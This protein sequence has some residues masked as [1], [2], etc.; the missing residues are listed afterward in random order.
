MDRHSIQRA[1][2]ASQENT[3][4]VAAQW[5]CGSPQAHTSLSL[6]SKSSSN[7]VCPYGGENFYAPLASKICPH[8]RF[9]LTWKG[10]GYGLYCVEHV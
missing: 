9:T 10:A 8:R 5:G 7:R 1:A 6:A 3:Q 2:V 4:A